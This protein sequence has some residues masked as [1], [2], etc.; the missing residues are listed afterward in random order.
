MNAD[1]EYIGTVVSIIA[2]VVAVV[3]TLVTCVHFILKNVEMSA[4]N[5]ASLQKQ[6]D[7]LDITLQTKIDKLE[8][9]MQVKLDKVEAN[10]QRQID[11][12]NVSLS[13]LQ[14]T[15]HAERLARLEEKNRTNKSNI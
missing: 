11:K 9:N 10:L 8:A 6:I 14:C 15:S 1:I 4:A 7:K 13:S 2:G 12:T 5:S 3:A